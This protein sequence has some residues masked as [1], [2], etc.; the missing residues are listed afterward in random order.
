[1][2]SMAPQSASNSLGTSKPTMWLPQQKQIAT[3]IAEQLVK[4][5]LGGDLGESPMMRTTFQ[6]M[7]NAGSREGQRAASRVATTPGVSAP[8]RGEAS[9]KAMNASI[10]GASETYSKLLSSFMDLVTSYGMTSGQK[11][12]SMSKGGSPMGIDLGSSILASIN[13]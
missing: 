13:D 2:G 8:M 9:I 11:S 12:T 1:M 10:G 5:T 3:G 4:P 6:Q 7:L